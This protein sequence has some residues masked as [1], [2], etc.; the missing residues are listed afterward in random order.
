MLSEDRENRPVLGMQACH[1]SW[2]KGWGNPRRR[3]QGTGVMHP[4]LHIGKS[5]CGA[6]AGQST[7]GHGL[8]PLFPLC[9]VMRQ[10]LVVLCQALGV[11]ILNGSA[12]RP[13]QLSAL[14]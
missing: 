12:Y 11:E 6:I 14:P 8:R 7:V 9:E 13:V 4:G 10:F 5:I 3:L 2:L 1:G